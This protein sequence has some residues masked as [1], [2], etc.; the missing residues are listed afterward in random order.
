MIHESHRRLRSLALLAS[1]AAAV[2]LATPVAAQA[3]SE[4]NEDVDPQ[5][6]IIVTARKTGERL[7]DVPVTVNAVTADQLRDRGAADVKDV[8]RSIPG[9]SY[10]GT[11]RGLSNYN[12]RGISTVASSPTVGIYLDD[13]S[14]VTIATSFSG[15]FDPVFFDM[16]RLEVLKG[17]Q[18]TLYGGNSMGGAIKY[19]SARPKINETE[20][21]IA[22]GVAVTEH[23]GPSY[24]GEVVANVPLVADT[25]AL[26]GGFFYR[27]DGGYIDNQPGNLRNSHYSSTASPVYTPL[28]QDT[29][30]TR[31]TSNQNYGDTFA[32][33]LSLEWQPDPSWSI[34]PQVFYQDYTLANAGQL[35]I[36]QPELTSSY[37]IKQPT[38]DKAGIYSLNIDKDLGRAKITS[39]T[40]YFDRKLSFVRD[41]SY[42]IGNLVPPLFPLTARNVSDSRT[43]TFSQELRIASDNGPGTRFKWLLGLYYSNQDDRLVQAV[44]QPGAAAFVGADLV[45]YGDTF[46]NTKQYAAFG[47]VT[48]TVLDGLDLTAG[49]RGFKIDQRVDILGDGPFNGGLTVVSGRKSSESGVNPKF[50]I[51]YKVARDNLLYA[52]AAKGFRPG[53]PNRFQINPVLCAADLN[54]L[55]LTRAPD[56]FSSDNLWTYEVGTKNTFGNVVTFNAAA[57]YSDWKKIQQQLNLT[58]CGFAFT[59]NAGTAEVKGAEIEGQVRLS[60]SFQIGGNATYTD[61]TIK[62]AAPGTTARDGDMVQAVPKWMASAYAAFA[63]DLSNGW[64]LNMRGEYQYQSR[65]RRSFDRVLSIVYANAVAGTTPNAAEFR[66]GFDVVNLSA[67]LGK[68]GTEVRLYA[69]NLLDARPLI[70]LDLTAGS[71]RATTIRPRTVGVELRQRF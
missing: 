65:A 38:Y 3:A 68:G 26:R 14:L 58:S 45:Y 2:C 25:L 43:K 33:R 60:P 6:G 27:R 51:S 61:A 4:A 17:P 56:S 44:N 9:F 59:G 50:G 40:A 53:G 24:N 10:S 48:Y 19:V 32:A 54:A 12:I 66:Q 39:L 34:R 42:F 47:E 55:G 15:A 36:D 1:G 57:F 49:V 64:R 41:Y 11:E 28:V 46:T 18:G 62:N 67:S 30:S 5:G 8:L 69:N 23:G 31:S 52:S 20:V 21:S 29:L 37:R 71:D 35:F 13:I 16:E 7:Q 63:H 22:A 70:D